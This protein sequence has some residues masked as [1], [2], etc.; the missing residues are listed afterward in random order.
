MLIDYCKTRYKWITDQNGI[1]EYK[2][3]NI[4]NGMKYKTS[5]VRAMNVKVS[6]D[7][8]VCHACGNKRAKR[9]RYV[10]SNYDRICLFCLETWVKNS[11]NTLKE[12]NRMVLGVG[13][14]YK[15]NHGVWNKE[16]IAG[17]I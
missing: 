2:I 16:A 6:R 11:S 15:K 7:D 17:N 5:F 12:M 9:T 8:F 10:G 3:E 4:F 13:K 14:E 1:G